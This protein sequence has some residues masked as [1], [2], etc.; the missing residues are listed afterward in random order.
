M[1]ALGRVVA[2]VDARSGRV[3]WRSQA[4]CPAHAQPTIAA[5]IGVRLFVGCT[6]G[7]LAALDPA[8]GRRIASAQ[9]AA[10]DA[11]DRIFALDRTTIGLEGSASGAY[12][13]RQSAI[14]R[15]ATLAPIVALG[16]DL[17]LLGS[18]GER[19]FIDDVCCQGLPSDSAPGTLVE[20]SLASGASLAS[21]PLHPYAHALAPDRDLPGAGPALLVDRALYVAT[22]DALFAYSLDAVTAPP[23]LAYGGLAATPEVLDGRYLLLQRPHAGMLETSLVDPH[24]RM[25]TVWRADGRWRIF[26]SV[27]SAAQ[28]VSDASPPSSV[29]VSATTGASAP[30]ADG[31]QLLA[32]DGS[33][34][35][36]ACLGSVARYAL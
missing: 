22:H 36:V 25:R 32:A 21:V 2:R 9:P 29:V 10:L 5:H 19:A 26:V 15:A 1:L 8:T 17:L 12:L 28:L 30:I 31:C 11:Y 18:R 35:F 24:D 34:A 3:R 16:P 7:T 20:R 23:A 33:N 27:G 6:G 14:V 4:I 13:Y